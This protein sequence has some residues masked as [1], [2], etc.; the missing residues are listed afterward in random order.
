VSDSPVDPR[1]L[2][3]SDA[4][5]EHVVNLL[6]KAIGQGLIT[7]DEFT[8]RTDR[9]LA[10]RTRSELNAVLIDLPGMTHK[11]TAPR[12]VPAARPRLELR[13]TMSKL[14]RSGRWVVPR[15]LIVRNKMGACDL[16]FTEA[17][18]EHPVVN[19]ELDVTAGSVKMLLPQHSSVDVDDLQ[20][21]AGKLD[22]KA[23]SGSSGG[24]HF[25]LRGIVRAGSLT[26]KRPTYIRIG[27]LVIR[28]P[29]KVTTDSD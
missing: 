16:D 27:S 14:R 17:Q 1:D 19:I 8:E 6:Q 9:A 24:P 15:E 13:N 28:F 7:L 12:D 11:D 18:I 23:A 10:A 4:E 26:I 2:R 3:V 5:R 25:V 21:A 29:W 20:V 22:N